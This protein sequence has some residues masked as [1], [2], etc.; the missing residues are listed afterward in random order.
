MKRSIGIRT[1]V[2]AAALACMAGVGGP[3]VAPVRGQSLAYEDVIAKLRAVDPRAR[4]DALGLLRDAGYIDAVM[5]VAAL[6]TDPA[7]EVQVAAIETE[8]SLFLVDEAYTRT[9]GRDV[10]KIKDASLPLLAFAQGPGALVGNPAPRTLMNGLVAAIGS[11]DPRVRFDAMYAVGALGVPLVG[12]GQFPDPRTAVARLLGAL[13]DPDAA[14]RAAA[15]HV[16][17]RLF[18]AAV[19][20]PRLNTDILGLRGDVGDQLVAAMNDTDQAVR[21]SAINA[22][23]QI[24]YERAIR[25]LVDFCG[26]YKR[27]LLGLAALDALAHIAHPS[28]A[29]QF[30]TAFDVNDEEVRRISLEGMA[31]IGDKAALAGLVAR[32]S[33]DRSQVVRLAVAFAR[34]RAG[35]FSELEVIVEGFKNRE[36]RTATFNYLVELGPT[37]APSL[38]GATGQRDVKIR[39]GL[40]EVLGV[41]GNSSTLATLELLGRDRD[42][43]VATAAQRSQRRL[44]IRPPGTPRLP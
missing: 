24:R 15:T 27:D 35:D 43:T 30:A 31:R 33:S 5:P 3:A 34:A 12:R 20:D 37:V 14:E 9:V 10:V 16:L 19:R 38:G 2:I 28:S 32:A 21:L 25:S 18:E 41:I 13:K 36:L 6:L 39:A 29:G 7:P 8:V 23:G 4:L 1:R 26:Y 42:K 22:I 44:T 17:G 40:A 11:T